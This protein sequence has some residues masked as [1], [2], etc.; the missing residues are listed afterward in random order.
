MAV[1]GDGRRT[2]LQESLSCCVASTCPLACCRL[3]EEICQF[4]ANK[5]C[6][7]TNQTVQQ[8]SSVSP[9]NCSQLRVING[10]P[11][12]NSA[13]QG[14]SPA[15]SLSLSTSAPPAHAGVPLNAEDIND[16]PQVVGGSPSSESK[17]SRTRYKALQ[18]LSLYTDTW[19][20][21]PGVSE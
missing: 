5:V 6:T 14:A 12:S 7:K 2:T 1:R 8:K 20:I 19:H 3:Q 21:L 10:V 11:F 9:H 17:P 4:I 13:L 16:T 15:H 18:H